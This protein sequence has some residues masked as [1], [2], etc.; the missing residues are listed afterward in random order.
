MLAYSK[1]LASLQEAEKDKKAKQLKSLADLHYSKAAD[2]FRELV[3]ENPCEFI[4]VQLE[5]VA[6]LEFCIESKFGS[7]DVARPGSP[8][9][10]V[11][12]CRERG[13]AEVE[14]RR[15]TSPVGIPNWIHQLMPKDF[16]TSTIGRP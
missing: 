3:A 1:T 16:R 9:P 6:L 7:M 14:S 2:G 15:H 8:M 5:R 4:R 10:Y 13:Q 12:R 11:F